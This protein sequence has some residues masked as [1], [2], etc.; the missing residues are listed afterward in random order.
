MRLSVGRK[1]SFF[2]S[3][4][5]AEVLEQV[6]GRLTF[7]NPN[8]LEAEKRRF[9]TGNIPPLIKGYEI[10]HGQ[11]FVPRGS[12]RQL[13]MI[14]RKAGISYQ[15]NDQRRSLAKVDFTFTGELYDFQEQAVSAV[16]GRDFGVLAAPTGSGKTV[17]ALDLIAIRRQP[18]LVA[19]HTLELLEQWVERIGTFLGIPASEVGVIGN[20]KKRIGDKVTVALV[21][22]LYKIAY[23]VAPQIG[24][25]IADECHRCPSRTFTEAVSAFDCRYMLGLSATPWRGMGSPA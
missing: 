23:D 25:L 18:A 21:Q 2:A 24:S 12:T 1:T 17:M 3:D 6:L 13:M 10:A 11:V 4:L 8:Y 9:Y 5:P 22:S 7:P 16:M 14:L 19:V 15:V 20:G